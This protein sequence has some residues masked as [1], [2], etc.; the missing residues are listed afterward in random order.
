M[1]KK[2]SRNGSGRY[3]F[4]KAGPTQEQH[5]EDTFMHTHGGLGNRLVYRAVQTLSFVGRTR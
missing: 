4:P 2:H 3:P 5:A 1:Q